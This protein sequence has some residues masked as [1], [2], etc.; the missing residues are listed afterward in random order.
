[1][2]SLATVLHVSDL[3]F[4]RNLYE[5]G[6]HSVVPIPKRFHRWRLADVVGGSKSHAFGKVE[7]L[8]CKVK[9]IRFTRDVDLLVATGDLALTGHRLRLSRPGPTS[10]RTS[11]STNAASND[12]THGV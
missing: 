9:E 7:A 8:A 4:V 3:H 11:S 5:P 12:S 2:E 10:R 1:M 6:T